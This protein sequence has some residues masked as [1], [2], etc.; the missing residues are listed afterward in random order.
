MN[1]ITMDPPQSLS[2]VEITS[3]IDY[4]V[5]AETRPRY[6]PAAKLVELE[7]GE[8]GRLLIRPSGTEPKLK[9]YGDLQSDVS[10][11]ADMR[12]AEKKLLDRIDKLISD[13]IDYLRLD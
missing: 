2:G 3:V 5:G 9:I 11:V 6:L 8:L 13:L 12:S 7:L 1:Q 10:K 4:S